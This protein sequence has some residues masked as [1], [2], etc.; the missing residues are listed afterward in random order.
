MLD[1]MISGKV[2]LKMSTLALSAEGKI[3]GKDSNWWTMKSN[4]QE[5]LIQQYHSFS[6]ETAAAFPRPSSFSYA[7]NQIL[8]MCFLGWGAFRAKLSFHFACA[9]SS[10]IFIT[11]NISAND[12]TDCFYFLTG[13]LSLN[14]TAK[15][16]FKYK[17]EC[18]QYAPRAFPI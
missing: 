7:F 9:V 14:M 16:M 18:F 8:L 1:N 17:S 11:T 15:K 2:K 4:C 5:L 6:S 13:I 10:T 3:A 12:S